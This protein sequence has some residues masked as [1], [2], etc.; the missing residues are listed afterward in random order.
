MIAASSK[1][2]T[3]VEPLLGHNSQLVH[4]Y[5]TANYQ[6]FVDATYCFWWCCGSV[7]DV[8]VMTKIEDENSM[9]HAVYKDKTT[10]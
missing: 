3:G 6:C 1:I 2:K 5:F 4:N 7:L 9:R 8:M 10:R